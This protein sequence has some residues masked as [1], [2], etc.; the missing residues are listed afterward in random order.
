MKPKRRKS[1]QR[2]R[3]FEIIYQDNAHPTAQTVYDI[4]RK[5]M[6]SVSLGNVYRNIGILVEEGRVTCRNFGDGIEH[7]DAILTMHYHFI[8]QRCNRVTDFNMP[9]QDDIIRLAKKKTGHTI[10]GHTI[11]FFGICDLCKKV[12]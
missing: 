2:E 3:I 12:R 1:E 4:L 7:Y 5:E 11:H 9:V 8:C 10:T 6:P